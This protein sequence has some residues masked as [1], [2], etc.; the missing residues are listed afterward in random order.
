MKAAT[1]ILELCYVS[2]LLVPFIYYL[3]KVLNKA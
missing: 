2:P 3:L 1:F